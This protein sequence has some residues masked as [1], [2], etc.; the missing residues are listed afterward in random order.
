MGFTIVFFCWGT[1]LS[2]V[3]FYYDHL[4]VLVKSYENPPEDLLHTYTADGAKKVFAL[5]FGWLYGPIYS[6]PWL[7]IY[8][9][10]SFL[11]SNENKYYRPNQ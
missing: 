11:R 5:F 10:G 2:T 9:V 3:S 6:I 4:E 1:V 8:S 7:I